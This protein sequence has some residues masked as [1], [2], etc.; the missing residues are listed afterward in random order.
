VTHNFNLITQRLLQEAGALQLT[1]E[2]N[3]LVKNA[4]EEYKELKTLMDEVGVTD[5][6]KITRAQAQLLSAYKIAGRPLIFKRFTV[7]GDSFYGI[8]L[9]SIRHKDR[10]KK[11]GRQDTNALV[12]VNFAM[13]PEDLSAVYYEV[14]KDFDVR[15]PTIVINDIYV[16]GKLKDLYALISHE[17][18]HGVQT[19]KKHSPGYESAIEDIRNNLE[20]DRVDYYTDPGELEVQ[21]GEVVG[22]IYH[23]V[24]NEYRKYQQLNK[25]EGYPEKGWKDKRNSILLE[26]KNFLSSPPENYFEYKE[27]KIPP[28]LKRSEEFLETIV[29][30]YGASK[31]TEKGFEKKK[32]GAPWKRLQSALFNVYNNLE[33][34]YPVKN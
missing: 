19:Y 2:E 33:K 21:I 30:L 28:Y 13:P 10:N 31:E 8:Q 17:L 12:F 23:Y 1:P 29:G 34:K 25:T 32:W 20:W 16:G 22:N 26:L 27:L 15:Q 5:V 24:E 9:S 3:D 4:L 18:L 11:E 14:D 7:A 6:N